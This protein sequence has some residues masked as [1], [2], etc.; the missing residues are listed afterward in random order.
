MSLIVIDGAAG[1]G[2]G[3]MLRTALGLSLVTGR[4]FRIER[5]RAGRKK[6]GLQRQHL[7]AVRAAA[8]VGAAEVS[9]AAIGS[10]ELKFLPKAAAQTGAYHFA[11]GTA[12]S[13]TLVL[14]T[15]LPA[16]MTAA[17]PSTVTLEGGTHN[18]W[19]PPFDFLKR[20]FL[21]LLARMG[22]QCSATLERYGF[23][24]AGGGRV[25]VT[26]EP[27]PLRPLELTSRGPIRRRAVRAVVSRLPL[28]IAEREVNTA[29]DVL[30]WP[31]ECA[32]VEAVE[33]PGPGNAVSIDVESD[34]L[35]EVFVGFGAKGVPAETVA[36]GAAE[37]ARSYLAADVPVGEHLADQL[38]IPL[39]LAGGGSFV[40]TEPSLHTTTNIAVVRKFLDVAI[41]AERVSPTARRVSV[42]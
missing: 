41:A 34:A 9:G 13:T 40:T 7:A 19:A 36:R 14:Q 29:R 15:V 8:E 12:G 28:S 22:P 17:G 26:I 24:P 4:G 38:L 21:P 5:V 16:L 18:I 1:E 25:A 32:A 31:A 10:G 39:A 11:V 42:G 20:T 33:S 37:A 27:A 35:T 3:Q 23:Y 6:P 30:D 2:G